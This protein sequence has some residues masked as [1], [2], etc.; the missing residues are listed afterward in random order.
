MCYYFALAFCFVVNI[1]FA[2]CGLTD[3][4]L[5]F[6]SHRLGSYNILLTDT[7]NAVDGQDHPGYPYYEKTWRGRCP[8]HMG[9]RNSC[10]EFTVYPIM[11]KNF[12]SVT[13]HKPPK[14]NIMWWIEKYNGGNSNRGEVRII[15]DS[16]ES[17]YVYTIDHE[18][19]FCGP[20]PVA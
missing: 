14:N 9:S 7:L 12:V 18:K 5:K 17:Q 3:V 13:Y 15:T 2:Q 8:D 1:T 6:Y 11:N 10:L 19:T 20:Y 4:P 16:S